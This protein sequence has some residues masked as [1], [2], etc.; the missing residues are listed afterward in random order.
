MIFAIIP[1]RGGSQRIKKKNIKKFYSKPILYW[2]IKV[3][4][5][6]RLFSKIV[7]STDDNQI[8][9]I[10][11]Q[12]GF[13][14]IISRPA[15]LSNNYTPTKPVIEH[16]INFL[17]TKFKIKYVCCV[18]SC[19]PFLN[20][21]DLK[22]SFTIL[23]KN[24][25]KFVFPITEY[26]HPIQ[27]AFKLIKKNKLI[28]F[29][30]K[31]ELSRTQDLVKSYHDVGQFYWGTVTNWLSKKKLHSNGIGL[32]I[33]KWRV[34]DIDNLHDWKRAELLFKILEVNGKN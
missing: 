19:N 17:K 2:T 21:F 14:Y 32:P 7:L 20:S 25:K 28:F 18:Y 8:K 31:H 3:L 16:A 34:A 24:K 5:Q 10:G 30:K 6:S 1:A 33:P 9:K 27:R 13:D 23:K 29:K 11:E 15:N 26:A 4:R 22:K 12:L